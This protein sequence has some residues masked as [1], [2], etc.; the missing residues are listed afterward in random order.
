MEWRDVVGFESKYEVSSF[1]DVMN[2]RTGK[3]LN[4]WVSAKGYKCVR[5]SYSA[6]RVHRLVAESFIINDK[7]LPEVNHID[8]NKLNN[9]VSNLEW[10]SSR[11]NSAHRSSVKRGIRYTGVYF[12]SKLNKWRSMIRV[13]GKLIHIGLFDSEIEASNSYQRIAKSLE[14]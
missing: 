1:G 2:K 6:K 13:K 10:C 8:F 3:V 14:K 11:Y 5:I 4:G 9:H 12:V 7:H